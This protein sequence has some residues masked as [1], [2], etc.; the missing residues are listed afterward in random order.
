MAGCPIEYALLMR[1]LRLPVAIVLAVAALPCAAQGFS[2]VDESGTWRF[3]S[4]P[5][6]DR[7]VVFK[8]YIPPPP[9]PEPAAAEP[10][11]HVE[12]ELAG[13]RATLTALRKRYAEA[14]VQAAQEYRI[15]PALLHAVVTVESGY[16]ERAKSPKGASGLMQLM[17]ATAQRY[18]VTDIWDPLQNLR[19]GAKYLRDLLAMFSDNLQ[20][21]LAAYNAGEGA[22][23]RSGGRIPAYAETRSYV[24][25]VIDFYER[26][27]GSR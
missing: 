19:G 17:P 24:P 13:E 26:Y 9:P 21:A 15:E 4:E 1:A 20:L 11:S 6:D 7:Y 10:D 3:S 16:N 27:R 14:I 25:R 8:R 2:F 5:L 12:T 22:V 23:L 18:G